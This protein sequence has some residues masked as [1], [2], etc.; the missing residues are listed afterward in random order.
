M[1]HSRIVIRAGIVS[2]L[3]VLTAATLALER[4][5]DVVRLEGERRLASVALARALGGGW[6]PRP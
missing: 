2:Y 5:L 1:S 3:E 4:E 6:Q